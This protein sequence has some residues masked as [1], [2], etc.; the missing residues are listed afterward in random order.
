MANCSIA[1]ALDILGNRSAMLIL[2]ESFLGTRRFEDFVDR[3]GAGEPAIAARLKALVSAELLKRVPYRQPGQRTRHE[4]QLT[5]KGRDLLPVITA[6]R[7]WGDTWAADDAGPPVV[8]V[9]RDCGA[10]VRA[11]VL[12]GH[13]HEVHDGEIVITAGPGLIRNA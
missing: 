10:P 13:D 6:L 9:H 2:R 5:Q 12:C 8:A 7:V 4:Y 3:V 11:A 1:R